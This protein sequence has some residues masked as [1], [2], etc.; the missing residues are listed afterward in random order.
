MDEND[1]EII[2]IFERK[3]KAPL[4]HQRRK[5]LAQRAL[6][7]DRI[8]KCRSVGYRI[9]NQD[10]PGRPR[11]PYIEDPSFERKFSDWKYAIT[12]KHYSEN[13]VI[14]KEELENIIAEI[15]K[16]DPYAVYER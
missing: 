1:L 7:I 9:H 13:T 8:K 5:R 16:D 2:E 11:T 14:T 4:S 12:K 15:K 10:A 6:A 3:A